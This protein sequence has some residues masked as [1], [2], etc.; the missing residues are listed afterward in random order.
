MSAF[1]NAGVS[2]VIIGTQAVKKPEF[3]KEAC[4]AYPGKVIVGI[5]AIEGMVATEGWAEVSDVSAS[6]SLSSSRIMVSKQ[7]STPILTAMA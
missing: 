4:E 6:A 5:D 7:S 1:I 2:Y 3:V